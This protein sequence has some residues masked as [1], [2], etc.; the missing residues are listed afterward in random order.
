MSVISSTSTIPVNGARTV[1]ANRAPMPAIAKVP[2]S[3][4]YSGNKCPPARPKAVPNSVPNASIGAKMPPG[5]PEPKH[6]S[7]VITRVIKINISMPTL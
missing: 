4:P 6:N 7:V 3:M 5:A 2:A 1:A